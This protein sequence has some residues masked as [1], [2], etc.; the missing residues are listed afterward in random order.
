M[1][2]IKQQLA[3]TFWQDNFSE[4]VNARLEEKTALEIDF[5][6]KLKTAL[7]ASEIET[8]HAVIY[9]NPAIQISSGEMYSRI[10]RTAKRV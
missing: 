9:T 8:I 1:E 6:D 2:N 7:E 10:V 3:N 5:Y 4:W